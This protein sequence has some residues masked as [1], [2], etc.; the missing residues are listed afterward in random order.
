MGREPIEYVKYTAPTGDNASDKKAVAAITRHAG[1][2]TDPREAG[3]LRP[4]GKMLDF[5][6]K[7]DGGQPG[8]RSYDHRDLPE[9]YDMLDAKN[10]GLARVDFVSGLVNFTR[11]L[12][13]QQKS[14]LVRNME[15]SQPD[16]MQV[17]A[18]DASTHSTVYYAD[19][20]GGDMRSFRRALNEAEAVIHGERDPERVHFSTATE[21]AEP[22][23][24]T[25]RPIPLPELAQLAV[26]MLGSQPK[27]R[28]RMHALGYF[29][30]KQNVGGIEL[31]ADIFLGPDISH[32]FSRTK[33]LEDQ[34]D[35]YIKEKGLSK[36]DVVIRTQRHGDGYVTSVY[37]RD[38]DYAGAVLAHE[39]GHADDWLPDKNMGRGNL[40]GR[41]AK[42]NEYLKHTLAASEDP[43]DILKPK[44]RVALRRKAEKEG[45]DKDSI[46]ARYKE[47]VR[48]EIET[49]NLFSAPQIKAEL[50]SVAEW[51]ADTKITGWKPEGK[52]LYAQA[53]SVLLNNP[54]ALQ[55]KAPQFWNALQTFR[56]KH[57]PFND[58][59]NQ[60]LS[61]LHNG[62]TPEQRLERDR[63]MMA[64]DA[65]V[66]DK[67]I[68]ERKNSKPKRRFWKEIVSALADTTTYLPTKQ[69]RLAV[70]DI[71]YLAAKLT[72]YQ[73]D[74]QDQI[75]TPLEQAGVSLD[76]F[77]VYL[78][79]RRAA[80]E[81][82]DLA[83]PGLIRGKDAQEVLDTLKAKIGDDAYATVEK[84][85]SALTKL[86]KKH[87]IPKLAE[88]RLFS[89]TLLQ[90]I[91]DNDEYAA[92][93]VSDFFGVDA[94]GWKTGSV[95]L[96]KTQH[97]TAK[98][99]MNPFYETLNKDMQLLWAAQV[100]TAKQIM[101][102]EMRRYDDKNIRN[103]ETRWNGK[104][105]APVPPG[106][107]GWGMVTYADNGDVRGVYV[108]KEIADLFS[109]DPG[110]ANIGWEAFAFG[111]SIL[112]SFFTANN[113]MFSLWNIQR[114]ARSTLQNLPT[115]SLFGEVTLA[116]DLALS[117]VK[118]IRDA[119]LHAYKK[120]STPL[121]R[122]LLEQGLVIADR[123]WTAWDE[124]AVNEYERIQAG[125]DLSHKR[126]E[127]FLKTVGRWIFN[128]FNQMVEIWSKLAGAE[129]M[130]RK[131]LTDK[132]DMRDI[133]RGI[134][135]SPDFLTRGRVTR[136]TN[137]V[138][139]YSNAQIQGLDAAQR[140]FR[141][142]PTKYLMRRL[143]Y[144]VVPSLAVAYLAFGGDDDDDDEIKDYR[145]AIRAIP[146][147]EKSR[148]LTLPIDWDGKTVSWIPMPLDHIGEILHTVIW[149]AV[150][151]KD[152][153]AGKKIMSAL[154]GM[155]PME[156]GSINPILDVGRAAFQYIMGQNPYD[157]F[158]GRPAVDETIFR[159]GGWRSR[160]EFGKW[161]WNQTA[162]STL[163]RFDYTYTTRPKT[164]ADVPL[165]APAL[166]RFVRTSDR[167]ATEKE[168]FAEQTKDKERAKI[169]VQA[170]DFAS[171]FIR[172]ADDPKQATARNAW[173]V[174]RPQAPEGYTYT[175]FKR[176]YDNLY[177]KR[178]P[179]N[180]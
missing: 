165:V 125:F 136:F 93:K 44:D 82:R 50:M 116:P 81:R 97:G 127:H 74:I 147:N 66:R 48:Q 162:G 173:T 72:Q 33:P 47:L 138:F 64:K 139:L 6:G 119:Y 157:F 16:Y 40:L 117:Y 149:N 58:L 23:E 56:E 96:I 57:T 144:S 85:A 142:Q 76:D 159:A 153:N 49:R 134:I 106:M 151:S 176:V 90:K 109:Q 175:D 35:A 91:E 53:I 123:Q 37:Q 113:P 34:I 63:A 71:S 45:T 126:H 24:T 83:N 87:I 146:D 170:K 105:H 95:S 177:E 79:R 60:I 107:P 25:P 158:R 73:R 3:Y 121:M 169:L 67:A 112:K 31:R 80:G 145:D 8:S 27:I 99:I 150:G 4:D 164:A 77:G 29:T 152:P 180:N 120:H 156:P 129:Y 148:M 88:S 20:E 68:D 86:R 163:G 13:P 128:D 118:T 19:M 101:A 122:E 17:E 124:Q 52:E 14:V 43:N 135:G 178:W 28:R 18:D 26:D 92:F 133:M 69:A 32:A 132:Y 143:L 141:M 167:G 115:A 174:F 171:E 89:P 114:D 75:V 61:D 10:A 51:W 39:M 168:Y 94:N 12:T 21:S 103:A 102:K 100:N 70:K 108:R 111:T 54:D 22:T 30:R 130:K 179:K 55:Q 15:Q 84:A 36:D 38:H 9:E 166:R 65:D 41:I 160:E 131:G 11:P 46:A 110:S 172:N 155:I 2:T 154:V 98:D 5:S 140:A 137:A 59:Y 161:V 104:T 7:R 1:L 78:M 42:L 62:L